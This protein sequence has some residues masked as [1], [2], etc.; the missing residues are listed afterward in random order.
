MTWQDAIIRA[1]WM[2]MWMWHTTVV[3]V[4]TKHDIP[5]LLNDD[6]ISRRIICETT[7]SGKWAGMLSDSAK[8]IWIPRIVNGIRLFQSVFA[9]YPWEPDNGPLIQRVFSIRFHSIKTEFL[10]YSN[11]HYSHEPL[12][13]FKRIELLAFHVRDYTVSTQ[14]SLEWATTIKSTIT[15]WNIIRHDGSRSILHGGTNRLYYIFDPIQKTCTNS[16]ATGCHRNVGTE[17]S[18]GNSGSFII[19]TRIQEE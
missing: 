15:P 8:L 19:Y 11:S 3:L 14:P 5:L 10:F 1:E 13:D 6:I 7:A 4:G 16:R 18:I 12:N 9:P 17:F 2:W